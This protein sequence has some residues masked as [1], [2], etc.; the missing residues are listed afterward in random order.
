MDKCDKYHLYDKCLITYN[1]I[2][3]APISHSTKVGVC[4]GTKEQDECSCEG[5]RCNCDFYANVREK[6]KQEKREENIPARISDLI[7][8]I[9]GLDLSGYENE[10]IKRAE[11]VNEL[12]EIK[13]IIERR[14]T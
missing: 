14:N 4:S 5:N 11:I 2:T 12:I 13:T 7:V 10:E 9:N 3:G 1:P 6:A 8:K